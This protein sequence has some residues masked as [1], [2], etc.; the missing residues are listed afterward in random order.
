MGAQGKVGAAAVALVAV[1][2]V[3]LGRGFGALLVVV[4]VLGALLYLGRRPGAD[5]E[6]E[7]LRASIQL[8]CE[9]VEDTLHQYE[10][11]AHGGDAES[12]ADR[13]LHR[14]ALLDADSDDPAIARFH[15]ER[16][17]ARRFL[18]RIRAKLASPAL[19]VRELEGLLSVADGRASELGQSWVE[20]R[21]AAR[22][23]GP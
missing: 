5:P 19:G 2:A 12:L 20:A 13:T 4:L 21:R 22:H 11:F 8:A 16:A 1:A 23:L 14:P 10:N 9:E 7:G 3:L 18:G 6:I 17:A 15:F